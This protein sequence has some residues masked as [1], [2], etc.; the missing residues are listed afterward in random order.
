MNQPRMTP[1]PPDELDDGQRAFL[2]PFTD[3]N[4]HYPNIFGVLC[5]DLPLMEAWRAFGL[6]LM[7]GSKVDPLL[8]EVLILRTAHVRNCAYEWHHHSRIALR[9][10]MSAEEIEAVRSG[11]AA[12][13]DQVL[14][15]RVADELADQT[16][17]SDGTWNSMVQRFGENCTLDAVFTVG[18]YTVLA[19]G[20]NSADVRIEARTA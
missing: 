11:E 10:G 8:R 7:S 20:L 18:A 13:P 15:I 19:M 9:L 5:R 17:L 3:A 2:A 12:S 1:L 16:K 6:Y 14:M 4:G